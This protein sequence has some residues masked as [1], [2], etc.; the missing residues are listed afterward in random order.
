MADGNGAQGG[1]LTL[2]RP[3]A[4]RPHV[5]TLAP[6]PGHPPRGCAHSRCSMKA[7]GGKDGERE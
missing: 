6:G 5:W 4:P 7:S 3:I 2:I 1:L